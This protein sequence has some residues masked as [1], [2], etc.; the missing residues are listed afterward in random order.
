[1]AASPDQ[2][3]RIRKLLRLASDPANPHEAALAAERA[4]ALLQKYRLTIE[5][6][7]KAYGSG[8]ENI[9]EFVLPAVE[10]QSERYLFGAVTLGCSCQ[11]ATWATGAMILGTKYD[12]EFAGWLFFYLRDTL[13][14]ICDDE[15]TKRVAGLTDPLL[16]RHPALDEEGHEA[17]WRESFLLG[18][19]VVIHDRLTEA[20]LAAARA[21]SGVFS[22]GPP[23]T[24]GALMRVS[25]TLVKWEK[26]VAD[27]LREQ[28]GGEVK[29]TQSEVTVNGD[30][31]SAGRRAARGLGLNRP[32]DGSTPTRRTLR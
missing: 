22:D 7:D 6:L 21:A 15:W 17:E 24:E 13:K 8:T 26:T 27:Y 14:R 31:F 19:A 18:A 2:I 25:T 5:D 29:E 16:G 4:F 28:L 23:P 30:G 1:M 12:A 3:D 32:I 11:C 10:T 9:Y 20:K